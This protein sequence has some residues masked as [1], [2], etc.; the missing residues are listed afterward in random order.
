M[1]IDTTNSITAGFFARWM[2]VG[3][4]KKILDELRDDD[5]LSPNRVGN[6]SITRNAEQI[7]YIDFFNEEVDLDN[8]LL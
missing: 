2:T 4:M 8:Q 6:L 1:A 3:K 7:G 5:I